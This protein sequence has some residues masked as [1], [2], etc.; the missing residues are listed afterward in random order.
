MVY[1]RSY[2]AFEDKDPT[3]HDF[4]FHPPGRLDNEG[5]WHKKADLASQ[6]RKYGLL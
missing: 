4:W 6:G 3:Q 5:L 1:G 2:M